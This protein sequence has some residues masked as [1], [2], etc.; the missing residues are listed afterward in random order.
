MVG[1]G[2]GTDV[3]GK[4]E[5]WEKDG[6]PLS[7]PTGVWWFQPDHLLVAPLLRLGRVERLKTS[8]KDKPAIMGDC[9]CSFFS[10]MSHAH[11]APCFQIF[12]SHI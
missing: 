5:Q 11:S 1:S 8:G 7:T 9:Y 12:I 4:T 6:S 3:G 2:G 10:G